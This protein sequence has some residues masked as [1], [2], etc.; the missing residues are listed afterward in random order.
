MLLVEFAADR[1]GTEYLFPF[2][3]RRK[4][5][6]NAINSRRDALHRR[7]ARL[8]KEAV[9]PAV[10]PHSIARPALDDRGRAWRDRKAGRDGDR[11]HV[12]RTDHRPPP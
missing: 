2:E 7:L 11:A 10:V 6:K 8:Y 9:L 5:A 1:P 4:N 12:V 3:S